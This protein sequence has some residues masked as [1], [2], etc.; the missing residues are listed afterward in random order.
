MLLNVFPK[1]WQQFGEDPFLFQHD[2]V[3]MN[4]A[5][6]IKEWLSQFGLHRSPASTPSSTFGM[7]WNVEL[8]T[9]CFVNKNSPAANFI[10]VAW[11]APPTLHQANCNKPKRCFFVIFN[12]RTS[13]FF[14][15]KWSRSLRWNC[16]TISPT[17]QGVFVMWKFSHAFPSAS[18]CF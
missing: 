9:F 14:L 1:L 11:A 10:D 8:V 18:T 7:N 5:R 4:K 6:S 17:L 2:S 13:F 3:L 12:H 15:S 16:A